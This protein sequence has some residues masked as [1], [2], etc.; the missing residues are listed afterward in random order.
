MKHF[1]ITTT[2][3][4]QSIHY[5]IT[6]WIFYSKVDELWLLHKS[7]LTFSLCWDA[8]HGTVNT[9]IP[10][11]LCVSVCVCVCVCDTVK[12][13]VCGCRWAT[14]GYETIWVYPAVISVWM[15]VCEWEDHT[16]C[17]GDEEDGSFSQQYN[18]G[19]G[20]CSDKE[21]GQQVG[22]FQE[23][24]K[25]IVRARQKLGGNVVQSNKLQQSQYFSQ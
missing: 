19:E 7:C 17:R 18:D 10:H 5:S 22:L 16:Q 21:L 12:S 4:P 6:I 23:G 14:V 20:L 24:K 3:Q 25:K 9:V 1:C 8:H 11:C 13:S 2:V 15:A